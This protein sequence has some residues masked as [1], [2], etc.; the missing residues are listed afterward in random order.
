MIRRAPP[1]S[2]RQEIAKQRPATTCLTIVVRGIAGS[3]LAVG[4]GC[5]GQTPPRLHENARLNEKAA[6]PQRVIRSI[7]ASSPRGTVLWSANLETGDLSQWSLPDTPGG[8][9]AGGGVFNSGIAAANVEV[10]PVAH[11]GQH[12]VGLFID[13]SGGADAPT[14]G[15]RLFRWL[16]P[17]MYQELYYR[18]WYY[19]PRRYTADGSPA[20]WNVQSWKSKHLDGDDPFFS[21]NV[22]NRLD[23]SMYLYLYDQ[24][25][26]VSYTQAIANIPE[27][28]WFRTDTF[29]RCAPQAGH[30]TVWQNETLI[31]D[32][33]DVQTRYSDGDCRW[34]VNNY[35]SSLNPATVTI[36][37]DDAAICSRET[38][39]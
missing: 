29:F 11:S 37:V 4:L 22:G 7:S 17:K 16:E 24:N 32:A 13:T 31:L 12:S 34:S 3:A 19:F 30:V 28:Q 20:W 35:S 27:A 36:Y 10:A 18:V 15:T 2:G 5:R 14:S 9:K 33:A 23:G 25:K 39:P 1:I 8:P 38:C 26:R 6:H 21:L